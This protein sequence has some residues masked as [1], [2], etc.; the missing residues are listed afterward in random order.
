MARSGA[1]GSQWFQIPTASDDDA[2]RERCREEMLKHGF[3]WR[4]KLW[5]VLEVVFQG[6]FV[7]IRVESP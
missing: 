3:V 4:G 1:T 6:R 7:R 2:A 5:R